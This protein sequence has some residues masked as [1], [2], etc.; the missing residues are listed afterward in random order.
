MNRFKVINTLY[1]LVVLFLIYLPLRLSDKFYI[2]LSQHLINSINFHVFINNINSALIFALGAFIY[3]FIYRI[4]TNDNKPHCITIPLIVLC[5]A[6]IVCFYSSDMFNILACIIVMISSVF[7][8][9]CMSIY[10]IAWAN[11]FKQK[12]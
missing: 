12:N 6:V 4:Y 11:Y 8:S 5:P 7:I 1:L 10:G 3:G 2:N 9:Y